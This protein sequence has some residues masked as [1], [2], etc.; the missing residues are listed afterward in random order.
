M[1]LAE[2]PGKCIEVRAQRPVK[3]YF[4]DGIPGGPAE[5]IKPAAAS[6]KSTDLLPNISASKI[7][8]QKPGI[9][10]KVGDLVEHSV[11]GSGIVISRMDTSGDSLLEIEFDNHGKKRMM[12]N[13][14]RQF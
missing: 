6:W 14:T 2:L 11:F 7:K 10:F 9:R 3:A 13:Y 12:E 4:A 5:K 1:F 8:P